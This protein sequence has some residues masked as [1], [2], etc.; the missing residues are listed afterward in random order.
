[1]NVEVKLIN[2]FSE[3]TKPS[4]A[5][6][7]AAGLDLRAASTFFVN[8]GEIIKI[9]TNVAFA[10]PKGFFG[11]VR[12][13]SGLASKG[14]TMT[15]SGVI[16]SNYRGEVFVPLINLTQHPLKV[17]YGDRIAQ[18]VFMEYQRIRM[19]WVEELPESDRG[20]GGFGSTG[21]R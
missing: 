14:L 3:K 2:Q 21:K 12:P 1:V 15:S 19:D 17:D 4:Y 8:P 5:D 9:P 7:D 10:I 20:A 13:R 16:D 18:I 6:G 11:M